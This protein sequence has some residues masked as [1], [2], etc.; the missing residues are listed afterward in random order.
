MIDTIYTIGYAGFPIDKF[1]EELKNNSI[2]AVIDVRSSA[3]SQYY[4]DYNKNNLEL[5]L[6]KEGI[7]YRNYA[8]EFGARQNDEEY[9]ADEGYLDFSKFSKSEQYLEGIKKLCTSMGKGY[10][11]ALM[12][13]EKN[14]I[15][16]H[17]TVLVARTF[18]EK[19][20]KVVHLCPEGKTILQEEINL[21][22]LDCFFPLRAQINFFE[23]QVSEEEMLDQA[24]RMQNKKIGYKM[25]NDS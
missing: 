1:V 11:F 15:D 5:R 24:Y 25:E 18:F 23:N 21:Q 19:G 13:A 17:R 2:N 20:Y 8:K 6:K 10:T 3:F 4:S 12:C 16:C 9:Y 14:P 22:L 7:Y